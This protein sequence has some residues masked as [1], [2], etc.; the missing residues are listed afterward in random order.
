MNAKENRQSKDM[1]PKQKQLYDL[2]SMDSAEAVL[3]EVG[4]ILKHISPEFPVDPVRCIFK[5]TASLFQGKYSGYR[6][7]NTRYH[8]I[9]HTTAAFL[10]TARLI[11]GAVLTG[12]VLDVRPIA[13][14]LITA[15]VH[16]AGYIQKVD[17]T[18]GTGAKYTSNHVHRSIEFFCR[19]APS[20]GLSDQEIAAGRAMILCTDL[21]SDISEISFDDG[22]TEF[23]GRVLEAGDLIGQRADRAYPEKLLLLYHEFKEGNVGDFKDEIDLLQ[24]AIKF[25][26]FVQEHLR[27]TL[28][29]SSDYM[30]AH[31]KARWNIPEDLYQTATAKNMEYVKQIL[32]TPGIDPREYLRRG[33]VVE[34]LRAGS[35]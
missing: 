13:V 20:C 33:K 28:D 17:D 14:A 9:H 11:H 23:L 5:T 18:E 15:L 7:C 10:A 21:S 30:L 27:K 26:D 19:A 32:R 8:D 35:C 34:R 6:A 16:D 25:S 24:D 29:K 4:V 2:I 12:K 1:E 3:D 31:F 22:Q